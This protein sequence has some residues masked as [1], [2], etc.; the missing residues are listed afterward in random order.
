[1][2]CGDPVKTHPAAAPAAYLF[3]VGGASGFVFSH[4][5]PDLD[6]TANSLLIAAPSLASSL[7][8]MWLVDELA[9]VVSH[10][11]FDLWSCLGENL[12]T[13]LPRPAS[14]R[15]PPVARVSPSAAVDAALWQF[16]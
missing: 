10:S 16:Y 14:T 15:R 7:V 2:S 4:Q 1:V 6:K 9:A 13:L 3:A 12:S 8:V 11:Q 5:L